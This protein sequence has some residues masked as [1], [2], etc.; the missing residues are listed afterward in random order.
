MA[1]PIYEFS[2]LP[3]S[4][5][6]GSPAWRE[7]RKDR[8]PSF[9]PIVGLIYNPKSHRNRGQDLDSRIA[10]DV[11][12]AQ[13]G[14]RDQL[15]EALERLAKRGIDLLVINGGDGTIRDVLTCGEMI[16][17]DDWPDLAVLPKGKTNALAVDLG[18][19]IDWTLQEA[20]DAFEA[21]NRIKR[22]PLAITAI[23]EKESRALGFILGAGA[24]TMGTKA[25]QSAHKMGAF[26]SLAVGVTT[27]WGIL[28]T[29]F[30][31]RSNPWRS[32]AKMN[33]RLYPDGR[34]LEHSGVGDKERRLILL[35]S[36]LERFPGGVK[37][38]GSLGKGLKLAVADQ[39]SRLMT[40]RLPLILFE[41]GTKNLR[42]RGFHQLATKAF[43]IDLADQFILDG[44]AFPPGQ[45][46]VET[47][48][49][50]QF[51]VP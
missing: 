3:K 17:G 23:Q 44:E 18:G 49:E 36:T 50:I 51:V 41:L 37:P 39:I 47:G 5:L 4:K 32:G 45:Y 11:F 27:F 19:P 12:V 22:R 34:L 40:L 8:D 29:V 16:F 7:S 20:I 38:F 24:F 42:E 6:S 46:K 9:P 21:G 13:P 31:S 43:E 48:P 10:P 33:I 26:N 30:G 14:N 35:A 2:N 28:Q 25:G 1:D 15:P